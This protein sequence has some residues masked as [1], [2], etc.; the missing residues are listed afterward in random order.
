[1][2]TSQKRRAKTSVSAKLT[3]WVQQIS[4][5]QT[6]FS[7]TATYKKR[8]AKY[9]RWKLGS[10]SRYCIAKNFIRLLGQLTKKSASIAQGCY[11]KGGIIF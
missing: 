5:Q 1:M 11:D 9:R 10:I 7:S 6:Q 4:S 3:H 2:S 8:Q